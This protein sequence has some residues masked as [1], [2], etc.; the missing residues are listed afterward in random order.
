[1]EVRGQAD[2]SPRNWYLMLPKP[3]SSGISTLWWIVPHFLSMCTPECGPRTDW[4][5]LKDIKGNKSCWRKKGMQ[6]PSLR[7]IQ[8]RAIS[9][10]DLRVFSQIIWFQLMSQISKT[11]SNRPMPA[12][13]SI[14]K[15]PGRKV[16]VLQ[17]FPVFKNCLE[18]GEGLIAAGQ[19]EPFN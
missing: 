15:R 11:R 16:L 14:S 2:S 17:V 12:I 18:P 4:R 6:K 3:S 13:Y 9:L 10:K 1:M 19:R 7:G 5:S 8:S